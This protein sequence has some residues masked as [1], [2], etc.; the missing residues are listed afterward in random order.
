MAAGSRLSTT[1]SLIPRVAFLLV[2]VQG[3]DRGL[4]RRAARVGSTMI[5]SHPR[6][7]WVANYKK[8]S[9]PRVFGGS[10]NIF[11]CV[12]SSPFSFI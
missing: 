11:Q 4:R 2:L 7:L 8:L 10:V 6:C 5:R 1:P 12:T 9:K 3:S